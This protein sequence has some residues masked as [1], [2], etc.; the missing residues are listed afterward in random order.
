MNTSDSKYI[1]GRHRDGLRG[2]DQVPLG[3]VFKPGRF[4]RMFPQL[5]ALFATEE[6]LTALGEAMSEADGGA[7]DGDNPTIPAGY[8]YLGQFIDHDITF[9]TTA[10]SEQPRDPQAIFN[11]RTPQ[12]ELDSVY[13]TGPAGMPHLYQRD[14]PAKF[15]IGLTSATPGGGDGTLPTS[16]PHDL[17]RMPSTGFAVIGDPRNDENLV[18]AQ[19]HLAFMKFHNRVVDQEAVA[20]EAARRLVRWHYQWIV[21]NDFVRRLVEPGVLDDVLQNGRRFYLFDGEPYIPVEFAVAAYRLG[22]SMVRDAYNYNRVFR[23]GGVTP[24]SLDLLFR[25]S[26]LSGTGG[27]VPIPSDWIIDWRRFYEVGQSTEPV[28]GFSRKLD[29]MLAPRLQNVPNVGSLAA[30][31][32][33]RGLRRGLPSGQS[34][35]AAMGIAP[36]PPAAFD[37]PDPHPDA[38]ARALGFDAATPLWYYILKEAEVQ[39]GG[40]RLGAVGSRIIAEVFVGLLEGD[41]ESYLA[42]DRLWRPTLGRVPGQFEMADLLEYVG[43]L[44][45]I[46]EAA[47]APA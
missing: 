28:L 15:A 5:A 12:L 37:Q 22:H 7:S 47:L 21:L 35:A 6:D 16:M 2:L 1:E 33:R 30:A 44:N 42:Q 36:L 40:Q 23:F 3:T 39:G 17:P 10:L 19:T 41:P 43:E 29:P 4:G 34:V 45:P 18:V 11:F 8:T 24:A 31:N 46:G 20:F 9:D 25:F 27:D 38:K 13:G 32:L 26:G 14:N